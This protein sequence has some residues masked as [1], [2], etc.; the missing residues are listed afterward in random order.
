MKHEKTDFKLIISG[1]DGF[2]AFAGDGICGY[3]D[4]FRW[5]LNYRVMDG[6]GI[7]LGAEIV[8]G[9]EIG[10]NYELP[11]SKL[12]LESYGSHEIFLSYGFDIL[13][14]K[15]TNRYRSIRFL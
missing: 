1:F 13:R 10:Y 12:L 3:K 8:S 11:T 15:R 4:R 9:L 7:L 14:Q 5:G 2:L 6:V